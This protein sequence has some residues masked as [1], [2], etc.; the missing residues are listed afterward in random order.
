[1]KDLDVFLK[2]VVDRM[3]AMAQGIHFNQQAFC[4]GTYITLR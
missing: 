4:N 1:M 3:K 2:P